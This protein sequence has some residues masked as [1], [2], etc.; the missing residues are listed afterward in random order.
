MTAQQRRDQIRSILAGASGPIS[1]S[2][3]AARM[4][5]SRQIVVGDI[6]L[7]RA[8][9]CHIDATPRGYISREGQGG[10]VGLLACRHEGMEALRQELYLVV[11]NG[12]VA[13]DVKI[14]NPLYG[15]L[16]GQLQVASRYDADN[17]VSRATAQ[18]D[19]LLS[20]MTGGVH[21]HTILCPDEETFLR[22]RRALAEAGILYEK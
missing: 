4:G 9:G 14:E 10:Y 13:E 7:L 1:A 5:V 17:F 20:S 8:G 22:I 6:A 3:L 18:Q 12:G 21:L 11:D 2:A 15:E 19:S 16:T